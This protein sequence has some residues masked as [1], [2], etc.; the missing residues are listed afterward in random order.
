MGHRIAILIATQNF[1]AGP[2]FP[3][4]LGPH[5]DVDQFAQV[6]IDPT[7]GRF[8]MPE[9][10]LKDATRRDILRSVRKTLREAT[11][12]DTVLIYYSGQGIPDVGGDLHFATAD[13]EIDELA[14]TAVPANEVHKMARE[15]YC[16]TVILLLDCCFAGAIGRAMNAANRGHTAD[17]IQQQLRRTAEDA[18]GLFILTSSTP[19]QTS[20][21]VEDERDGIVMGRFTR[22]IIERLKADAPEL[23]DE[24]RFSHLASHIAFA[25]PGQDPREFRAD[26][27]GDPIIAYAP[28]RETREQHQVRILT[29]WL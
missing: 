18:K 6:L 23:P 27:Q 7:R 19:W 13:T 14:D 11:V 9:G 20:Q 4:L 5:N 17:L 12:E 10:P 21:E 28:P 24:V 16:R 3:P 8:N 29:S 1:T 25:F 2:R 15:S 22:A 26:A